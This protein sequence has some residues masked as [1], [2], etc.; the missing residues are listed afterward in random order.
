MIDRRMV[1]LGLGASV[2]GAML[3]SRAAQA[4]NAVSKTTA[5]RFSFAVPSGEP[6][7]LADFAGKPVLV[8]NTAS[9]CGYTPQYTGLQQLWSEFHERGLTIIAVPSNDFNQEPG[10][11]SDIA[12]LANK[13]YGVT[14]PMT[15]KA[16][17]TGSNA[18]PF[19]RWAAEARPKETPRWNFHKYLVGRDG[20]IADV[21]ASSVEPTDTRVKTAVAR[22]LAD[23]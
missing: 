6:I 18:H 11:G 3:A 9:Q 1:V 5:Y 7:R 14:F 4:D 22:M 8:V 19:Y 21:F 12:A 2:S 15:A 23:G 16:V 20:Y 13:E 17:V 10:V